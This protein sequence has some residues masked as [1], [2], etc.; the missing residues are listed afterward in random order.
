MTQRL[1]PTATGQFS[2]IS[3]AL[4]LSQ[5]AEVATM[6]LQAFPSCK[7]S[8]RTLQNTLLAIG[9]MEYVRTLWPALHV[10]LFS[11]LSEGRQEG[12]VSTSGKPT[13]ATGKLEM[14][15]IVLSLYRMASLIFHSHN[16]SIFWKILFL[17]AHLLMPIRIYCQCITAF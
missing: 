11:W 8:T 1:R 5:Q 6:E 9:M 16:E 17:P 7:M 12:F 4:L 15:V 3:Q 2:V 14:C 13:W 10:F